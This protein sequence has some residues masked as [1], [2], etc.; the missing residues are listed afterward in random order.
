MLKI[1][2]WNI[3][4]KHFPLAVDAK[5]LPFWNEQVTVKKDSPFS[6]RIPPMAWEPP[7]FCRYRHQAI[8]RSKRLYQVTNPSSFCLSLPAYGI[9][10]QP[11][12]ITSL[13]THDLSGGSTTA[14]STQ[15]KGSHNAQKPNVYTVWEAFL[16]KAVTVTGN[17]GEKEGYSGEILP[18]TFIK[19][20]KVKNT[21]DTFKS[22]V[23]LYVGIEGKIEL[24][25]WELWV[26]EQLWSSVKHKSFQD[27]NH[28]CTSS[29]QSWSCPRDAK[30][31]ALL[32]HWSGTKN[33]DDHL[34]CLI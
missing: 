14:Q 1:K 32:T 10:A 27:V 2:S 31:L 15:Q 34:C 19:K 28:G 33:T 7:A 17:K 3:W 22:F 26:P 5:Q 11:K 4:H 30:E 13:T 16:C 25:K 8:A 18:C 24:Q 9:K 29:E 20:I 21:L 23:C 12:T 6:C